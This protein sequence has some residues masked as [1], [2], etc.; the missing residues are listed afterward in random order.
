MNSPTLFRSFFLA[1]LS[2]AVCLP[3]YATQNFSATVIRV[4]DGDTLKVSMNTQKESVRLIGVDTPE[5]KANKKAFRDS[6]KSGHDIQS[7]LKLGKRA[8]AF[9]RS[10]VK[11]GDTVKLELDVQPRDRYGRILAYVYL[12]DGRM[13][14][15]VLIQSGHANLMTIP[16]N[17]RYVNRFLSEYH[18]A[19]A[20]H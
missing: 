20:K 2:L 11:P 10:V 16:P 14:N 12:P 8:A 5:S 7:I 9:T 1:L 6:K 17:V 13:L 19:A 15:E 18:K 3:L 4:V